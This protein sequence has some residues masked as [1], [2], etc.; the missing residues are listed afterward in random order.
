MILSGYI[1]QR[2]RF[3]LRQAIDQREIS[4]KFNLIKEEE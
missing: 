4:A 3:N 2:R 1:T